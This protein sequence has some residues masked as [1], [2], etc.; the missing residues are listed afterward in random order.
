MKPCPICGRTDKPACRP[1]TE[2]DECGRRIME[3]QFGDADMSGEPN[4]V[5]QQTWC[6]L[7]CNTTFRFGRIRM[8]GGG[9]HCPEC[10]SGNLHPADGEQHETD[11]YHGEIGTL[12]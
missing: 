6:C 2:A 10:D 7:A 8:K 5:M 11:A 12:N 9:L 4:D 3:D 1:S